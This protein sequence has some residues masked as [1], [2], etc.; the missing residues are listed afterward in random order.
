MQNHPS[1]FKLAKHK[2]TVRR[3]RRTNLSPF[4]IADQPL[5]HTYLLGAA[6]GAGDNTT[7]VPKKN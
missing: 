2:Q 4:S 1:L 3:R 5:P 6:A 7:G